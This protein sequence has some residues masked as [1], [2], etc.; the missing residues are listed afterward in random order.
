[1]NN[2]QK[3]SIENLAILTYT[4]RFLYILATVSQTITIKIPIT[5][6]YLQVGR[7]G[8]LSLSCSISCKWRNFNSSWLIDSLCPV[9]TKSQCDNKFCWKS[10]TWKLTEICS[11]PDVQK[12]REEMTRP[13]VTFCPADMP[14]QNYYAED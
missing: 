5:Q 12:R 11:H 1:M 3:R 9:L 2:L 13:T 14:T 7:I 10:Q 8:I 6:I 4:V